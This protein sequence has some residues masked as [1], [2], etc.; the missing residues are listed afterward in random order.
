MRGQRAAV[1]AAAALSLAAAAAAHQTQTVSLSEG[2]AHDALAQ[3]IAALP[4]PEDLGKDSAHFRCYRGASGEPAALS[5]VIAAA[6]LAEVVLIGETHDDAIAHELELYLV[7]QLQH[8]TP[9]AVSLEMFEADVQTVMDEY[10]AGLIRE[11]DMMQDARPWAN[12]TSDYRGL[13]EL[14]KREGI[15]VR[16]ANVPRRYVGAIG[17]DA[18][19]LAAGSN[20]PTASRTH[21]P[22]L[23]LPQ[24]SAAYLDHLFAD[25]LVVRTDQVQLDPNDI[26]RSGGGGG[27]ECP[28]IG[29][30]K[31][32][33]LLQPMLMWDAGMARSIADTLKLYPNTLVLH[34]CGSFHCEFHF[35]IAEMLQHYRRNT[36]TLVVAIYPEE[37]CSSFDPERH[38]GRADF[39]LLT[40]N[41]VP[42]SHAHSDQVSSP[43]GPRAAPAGKQGDE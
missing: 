35:G 39:V 31:R 34:V 2:A 13:V 27:S 41:T 26:V 19:A 4:P 23:P 24:P 21:L 11:A 43:R 16:A 36:R 22:P 1:T 28:Y 3:R 8:R 38:A 15:P 42:K 9:C 18:N 17:R 12:Y 5:E 14:A 10:L 40:D 30:R 7:L 20:W 32:D 33:G 29:V 25:A 37:D 6:E